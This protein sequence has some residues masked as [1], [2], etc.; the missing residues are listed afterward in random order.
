M[1]PR[2]PLGS[3]PGRGKGGAGKAGVAGPLQAGPF[4]M[5]EPHG[6]TALHQRREEADER[7][8]HAAPV[9][10]EVLDVGRADPKRVPYAGH[11]A[12]YFNYNE[13]Y[14]LCSLSSFANCF[15]RNGVSAKAIF[16][17]RY[18]RFLS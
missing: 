4:G 15:T 17:I 6:H 16:R 5:D 2:G 3:A 10:I 1:R 11:A 18:A 12:Q 9:D 13:Q 14:Q 8:P 7:H